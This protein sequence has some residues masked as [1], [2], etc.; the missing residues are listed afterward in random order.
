MSNR[1]QS[2]EDTNNKL[3]LVD[4]ESHISR[5]CKV[6]ENWN[7]RGILLLGCLLCDHSFINSSCNFFVV[8]SKLGACGR[9]VGY[10][11]YQSLI[12]DVIVNV[13]SFINL[14]CLAK[15]VLLHR[16]PLAGLLKISLKALVVTFQLKVFI[17]TNFEVLQ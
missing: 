17:K 8:L 15:G 6:F 5:K 10:R 2:W 16:V 1:E 14:F 4:V 3:V 11:V 7:L 13:W 9:S 12:A